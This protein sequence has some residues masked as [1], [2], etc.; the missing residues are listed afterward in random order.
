MELIVVA[1]AAS[2][3]AAYATGVVVSRRR[4]RP[5]PWP[6]PALWTAGVVLA[7]ISAAG[8]LAS[9]AEASFV[10]HMWAHLLG[11]MLAPL[12]LVLAAPVTLALRTLHVTPAR[13]LSRLLRS[14]PARFVAHPVTALALSSGGLWLI[15]R[16]PVF[17][18]M[19]ADPLLRLVVHAHLLVA[20][21]LFTAAIVGLDPRPHPSRR[22]LLAIVLVIA[23]ASHGILAK[24]LAA[25]PPAAVPADDAQA[26]A[27]LM[28][29][30]GGWVEAAVILV[31][32]AQWYRAA[33]RRRASAPADAAS[34]AR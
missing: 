23:V 14:G 16:T 28:Y 25:D 30:L 11:G 33:G 1:A 10:A 22:T 27:Q 21:C 3:I 2:A 32:C 17:E 7:A 34:L 13:R 24:H 5:W 15:Y 4:G 19:H 31:F 6:R 8:P 9:A 26:G 29:S 20:G 12:L 18:A